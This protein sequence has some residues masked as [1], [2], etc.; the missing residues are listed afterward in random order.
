MA[1]TIWTPEDLCEF[2][3][4]SANPET[5][6]HAKHALYELTN[7]ASTGINGKVYIDENGKYYIGEIVEWTP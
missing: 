3:N 7:D 2:I 1:D 5:R 4:T 6:A